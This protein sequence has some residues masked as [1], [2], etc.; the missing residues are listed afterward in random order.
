MKKDLLKGIFTMSLLLF[1]NPAKGMDPYLWLEDIKGKRSLEWVKK[2]SD[3]TLRRLA[4]NDQ[5][6]KDHCRKKPDFFFGT[7]FGT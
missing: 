3:S 1:K 5:F 6:E 4:Q 2:E 7:L